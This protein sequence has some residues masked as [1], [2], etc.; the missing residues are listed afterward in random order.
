MESGVMSLVL[1]AMFDVTLPGFLGIMVHQDHYR[2]HY[3]EEKMM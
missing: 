2:V 1:G 3:R